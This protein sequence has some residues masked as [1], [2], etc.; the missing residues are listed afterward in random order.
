MNPENVILARFAAIKPAVTVKLN[1]PP[2]P[3]AL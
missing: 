3:E 1:F 2:V